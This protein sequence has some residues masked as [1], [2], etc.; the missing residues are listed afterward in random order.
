LGGGFAAGF[1][2]CCQWARPRVAAGLGEAALPRRSA[3]GALE[4]VTRCPAGQAPAFWTRGRFTG[5]RITGGGGGSRLLVR[6]KRLGAGSGRASEPRAADPALC[7]AT[8]G[9]YAGCL[10]GP[11]AQ[12]HSMI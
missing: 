6:P 8:W 12:L 5:L 10:W 4:V 7:L 11:R 9:R 2:L 3:A 1:L